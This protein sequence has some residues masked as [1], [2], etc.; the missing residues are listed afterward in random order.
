MAATK[1]KRNAGA[2]GRTVSPE[3]EASV[4]VRPSSLDETRSVHP[5]SLVESS[6]PLTVSVEDPSSQ[7]YK[8]TVIAR[9]PLFQ[10]SIA[11]GDST[12]LARLPAPTFG[13]DFMYQPTNE[14]MVNLGRVFYLN[15]SE[16]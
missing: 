11:I 14:S 5:L 7:F 6:V 13:G 3:D 8:A 16:I 9:E 1:G 2:L 12:C 15:P 10:P 4:E